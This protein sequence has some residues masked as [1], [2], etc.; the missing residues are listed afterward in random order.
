MPPDARDYSKEPMVAGRGEVAKLGPHI[1]P[2]RR[3]AE[4]GGWS[5]LL[6]RPL[7]R[8]GVVAGVIAAV[9]PVSAFNDFFNAVADTSGVHLMLLGSNGDLIASEPFNDAFIGHRP[10]FAAALAAAATEHRTGVF[11]EPDDTARVYSFRRLANLPLTVVASRDR[12]QILKRWKADCISSL[13]ALAVFVATAGTLTLLMVRA[14]RRQRQ[15]V[16]ELR[17]REAQLDQ[18]RMML[19]TTI[20]NMGD[21]LSVFDR[22]GR[23]IAWNSR[24]VEMLDLPRPLRADT[25]LHDVLSLLADRGDFGDVEPTADVT[26]RLARFYRDIPKM[27]EWVTPAG[28]TLL[29]RRRTMQGGLV[30]TLYT[31]VTE[32]KAGERKLMQAWAEADVANRAKSEFLA[33]MSHELRTPLNAIIGFSEVICSEILGPVT[34]R[35]YLEYIEDIHASGLHLLAIVNDVLDMSKIEAGKLELT[36]ELLNVQQVIHDAVRMVSD[37]AHSRGLEIVVRLPSDDV[38]VF[39]DE[40]AIKQIALNLLSNAIK[41][42]Y[43]GTQIEIRAAFDRS[44]GVVIEVADRGIGMTEAEIIRAMQPFGQIRAAATRSHSGTGLGLPITKGLIEAHGGS[45][46]IE[47][48]PGE[49]TLARITLPPHSTASTALTALTLPSEDAKARAIA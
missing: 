9:V 28:R 41:F 13:V 37:R 3:N 20:D 11:V 1:G 21:G 45:L 26:V 18:Q 10:A 8:G 36:H 31:D 40:R 17:S 33:N 30:V 39:A 27:A 48:K 2:P 22:Q 34:D 47:S 24:F 6:S 49:G 42:A 16:Q 35:K 46:V 5:V 12:S 25:T 7:M 44:G 19:Q 15:A 29:L 4:T 32:R 38:A 23:L 14:L 43:E